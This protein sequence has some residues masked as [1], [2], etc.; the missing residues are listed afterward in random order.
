M[1]VV[2][3]VGDKLSPRMSIRSFLRTALLRLFVTMT[4]LGQHKGIGFLVNNPAL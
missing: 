1:E 4:Q 2:G 3:W